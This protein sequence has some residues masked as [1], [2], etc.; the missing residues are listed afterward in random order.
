MTMELILWR[1]AEAEDRAKDSDAD[2]ARELTKRGRRQAERVA[3]WLEPRLDASWRILVSPAI[4]TL[5]TVAPLGREFDTSEDVGLS[6]TARTVLAAASWP[7][8][9]R[10]V[11]VV[12]H[13]PTLGQVAARLLD[14][15]E[16]DVS[17]RKGALWWFVTRRREGQLE[18]VLRTVV[19]AEILG[20]G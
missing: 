4:R 3:E 20:G 12:G 8:G 17:I 11:V 1:H 13:Q 15:A 5:Q 2:A 16:G 9:D 19:D 14:G 6:A 10:N 7:D 18:T